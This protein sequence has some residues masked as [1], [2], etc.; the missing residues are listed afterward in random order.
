M[1]NSLLSGTSVGLLIDVLD[2]RLSATVAVCGEGAFRRSLGVTF[3]FKRRACPLRG[4]RLDPNSP[5]A[6]DQQIVLE[7]R[8]RHPQVSLQP[9]E[10]QGG[11]MAFKF[12]F[13]GSD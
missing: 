2:L 10:W 11:R 13:T 9:F 3:E 8:S 4:A 1:G 7:D 6:A 5:A 12:Q